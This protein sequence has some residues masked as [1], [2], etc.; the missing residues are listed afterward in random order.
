MESSSKSSTCRIS[1]LRRP[2]ERSCSSGA[3]LIF[4]ESYRLI[5]FLGKANVF[6]WLRAVVGHHVGEDV[7]P[8][9]CLL[10]R[11]IHRGQQPNH[12]RLRAVDE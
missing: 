10:D 8:R 6:A 2:L 11:E 4:A 12:G 5:P 1:G 7:E 3:G 9:V